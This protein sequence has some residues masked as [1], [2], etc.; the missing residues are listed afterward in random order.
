[1]RDD[2]GRWRCAQ[3]DKEQGQTEEHHS[4]ACEDADDVLT[5]DLD[6]GVLAKGWSG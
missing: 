6:T 5:H 2:I 1:V 4:L 3:Q